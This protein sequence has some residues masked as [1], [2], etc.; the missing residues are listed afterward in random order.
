MTRPPSFTR[1]GTWTPPA[2][3]N[4][5]YSDS[6]LLFSGQALTSIN[7]ARASCSTASSCEESWVR[8]TTGHDGSA[9]EANWDEWEQMS[10]SALIR[11]KN[12]PTDEEDVSMAEFKSTALASTETNTITSGP[13]KGRGR[14][15]KNPAPTP[16][17]GA[18]VTKGRSKTGCITCRRRKKKCDEGKPAC[19]NCEKNSVVCEGYN[20]KQ[21]WKN[22]KE[23]A[24]AGKHL[25]TIY[26]QYSSFSNIILAGRSKRESIPAIKY[27][28]F[29]LGVETAEDR[30]FLKH[31]A[32]CL[33]NV[34]TVESD[35]QNPFKNILLTLATSDQG[36]PATTRQGLMH[37]ILAIS[38]VHIDLDTPHGDALLRDNSAV[39]KVSLL[40]RSDY[41]TA[42]A[43]AC[44][45]AAFNKSKLL[46][47]DDPEYPPILAAIYC[48]MLCLVLRTLIEG[49][50]TGEHRLHLKAYQALIRESPPQN[51]QLYKFITDFFQYCIYADDLLWHPASDSVRLSPD[52]SASTLEGGL[53]R[54]PGVT[55]GL[56]HHLRGIATLRNKIRSKLAVAKEERVVFYAEMYEAEAIGQTLQSWTPDWS[57][58]DSETN[59]GELYKLTLWIYTFRTVYLP[60]VGNADFFFGS[61]SLSTY[62]QERRSSITSS[63]SQLPDG[64]CED[65]QPSEQPFS[66]A[67]SSTS[68]V[69]E[70]DG[71]PTP[72]ATTGANSSRPPSPPSSRRPSQDNARVSVSII[73][74]LSRL[75]SFEPTDRCQTMLLI[76][77]LLIGAC[78]FDAALRPRIRAAVQTVRDYTGLRNADQVQQILNETWALM[79]SGDWIAAW[80]WQTIAMRKGIDVLCA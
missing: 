19:M 5:S 17:S 67:A 66:Y 74:A 28:S 48:Q 65:K 25:N 54:L 21:I 26:A 60:A 4:S 47:R 50:P 22:G 10:D 3:C 13:K 20:E 46:G 41:H 62:M 75:E 78:C 42:Q 39:T 1:D 30:I 79:D 70:G 58:G 32:D 63:T 27:P 6:A 77:C 8:S 2:A 11:P 68:S 49:S 18:K 61:S 23:R 37:S 72:A 24:E 40:K 51:M 56:L 14:P 64:Y 33:S 12:E 57:N 36:L 43:A 52:E 34:L 76:P 71:L 80:D 73:D 9:R 53:L 45:Q 69:Y 59:V 16:T 38:S 44:L 29:I 35:S 55:D 31:Y 15:R 7:N